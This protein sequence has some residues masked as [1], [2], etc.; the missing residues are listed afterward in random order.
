LAEGSALD[1]LLQVCQASGAASISKINAQTQLSDDKF[2]QAI[3]EAVLS[4]RI[5]NLEHTEDFTPKSESLIMTQVQ[6]EKET[7][8]I[9]VEIEQYHNHFPFRKGI[10]REELKSRLKYPARLFTALLQN[11]TQASL[12]TENGNFVASAAHRIE[13]NDKQKV[14]VN[15]LF[16]LFDQHPYS[17]P[18]VEECRNEVGEEITSALVDLGELVMVSTDIVFRKRDYEYLV[19]EV[20]NMISK[21]GEI[22]VANFRDRFKTSRRYALAFLEYLDAVGITIRDGDKRIIK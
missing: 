18:T 4:G 2:T 13:F 17:P 11:L 10:P 20:K 12:I 19:G 21:Q 8:K 1:I 22:T 6:W 15:L 7:H 5:V 16:E 14:K 3:Q 9:L